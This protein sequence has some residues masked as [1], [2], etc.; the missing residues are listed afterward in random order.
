MDTANDADQT[1]KIEIRILSAA[2]LA[3]D[4]CREAKFRE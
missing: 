4:G 3:G 2:D 1:G